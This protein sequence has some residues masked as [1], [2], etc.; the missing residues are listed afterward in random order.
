MHNKYIY[1][2]IYIQ[3]GFRSR[4]LGYWTHSVGMVGWL[5]KLLDQLESYYCIGESGTSICAC[6]VFIV[7][8][9]GHSG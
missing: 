6:G 2:K 1:H 3:S 4:G 9:T 7:Q 8:A 5:A